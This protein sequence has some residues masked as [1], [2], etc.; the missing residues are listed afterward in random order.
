LATPK[1]IRAQREHDLSVIGERYRKGSSQEAIARELGVSRS[2][3]SSDVADL[4]RRWRKEQIRDVNTALTLALEKLDHLERA[5]WDAWEASLKPR[6][7]TFTERVQR[8]DGE[9][10]KVCTRTEPG[11]G[12]LAHLAG[13]ASCIDRRCRLLGLYAL[14]KVELETGLLWADTGKRERVLGADG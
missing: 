12:N 8:A 2:Q 14:E 3:V 6:E 7:V 10:V 5:H 4:L 9:R 11:V 13:V 1:R